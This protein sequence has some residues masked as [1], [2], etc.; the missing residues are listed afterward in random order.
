MPYTRLIIICCAILLVTACSR[1]EE[2]KKTTKHIWQ[3]QVDMLDEAKAV[4]AEA[5]E[6]TRLKEERMR[7]LD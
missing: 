2:P 1:E 4:G 7:E 6:A 5:T 3:G